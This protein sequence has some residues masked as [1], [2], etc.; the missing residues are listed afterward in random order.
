MESGS[1]PDN[2]DDRRRKDRSATDM[3]GRVRRASGARENVRLLDLTPG[4]CRVNNPGYRVGETLWISIGNLTPI[5]AQVRWSSAH[6]AGLQFRSPLYPAVA[7]HLLGSAATA[8]G[9]PLP[10]PVTPARGKPANPAPVTEIRSGWIA[11]LRDP[12]RR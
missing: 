11:A 6:S 4:G 7:D 12:Y 5:E 8:P 1:Q 10:A 9:Q 2:A 3:L